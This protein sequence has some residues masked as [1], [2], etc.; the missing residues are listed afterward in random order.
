LCDENFLDN[1]NQQYVFRL[2]IF[3]IVL[4]TYEY[5]VNERIL[6]HT[7]ISVRKY[8]IIRIWWSRCNIDGIIGYN[9]ILHE[10]IRNNRFNVE[11]KENKK[12][13]KMRIDFIVIDLLYT[14]N[15]EMNLS[16]TLLNIWR[17]DTEFLD[18]IPTI[19]PE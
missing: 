2:K 10:Y 4:E 16:K 17:N 14:K 15:H 8:V 13:K 3:W 12:K 1:K 18:L 11:W 9:V 5:E 6:F 19:F 7:R